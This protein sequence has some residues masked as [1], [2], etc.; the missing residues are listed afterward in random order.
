MAAGQVAKQAED[1]KIADYQAKEIESS[2]GPLGAMAARLEPG[3]EAGIDTLE[4]Q[5][6]TWHL[7][8]FCFATKRPWP[9][10]PSHMN[11]IELRAQTSTTNE[12]TGYRPSGPQ[13]SKSNMFNSQLA[14]HCWTRVCKNRKVNQ[15]QLQNRRPILGK[16]MFLSPPHSTQPT[17]LQ[18]RRY[19][20]CWNSNYNRSSIPKSKRYWTG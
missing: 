15:K 11:E 7:A 20:V 6:D 8:R 12:Q 17:I 19:Q 18:W 5:P 9:G 2:R 13:L 14:K 4:R 16:S 3:R 1:A 10:L